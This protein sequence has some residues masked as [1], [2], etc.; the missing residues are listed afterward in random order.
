ME[1]I[2]EKF[3][4]DNHPK[5]RGGEISA[6]EAIRQMKDGMENGPMDADGDGCVDEDEFVDFYNDISAGAN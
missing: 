6:Q 5:V 2:I 1:F 3:N 4:A